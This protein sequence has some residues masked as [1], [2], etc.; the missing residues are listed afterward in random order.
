ML[1]HCLTFTPCHFLGESL[2]AML[3]DVADA[4]RA[5][6]PENEGKY[7]SYEIGIYLTL[8]YILTTFGTRVI[9]ITFSARPYLAPG[10][11]FIIMATWTILR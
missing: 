4:S 6:R 7:L 8:A 10:S 9:T 1:L 11:F 2:F 5:V 3:A